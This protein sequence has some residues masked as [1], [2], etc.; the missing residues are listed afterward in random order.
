MCDV[1]ED[2][3]QFARI[4]KTFPGFYERLDEYRNEDYEDE[5]NSSSD[6]VETYVTSP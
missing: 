2:I 5:E 3:K 4:C 6:D 1:R